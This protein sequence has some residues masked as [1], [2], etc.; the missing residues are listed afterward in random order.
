M[1]VRGQFIGHY[2]SALAFAYKHTGDQAFADR[3]D[4]MVQGLAEC[5]A[6]WGDGYLSAFP[7]SFWDRLESL[8]PVWAPYYVIHKLLAGLL[9]QHQLAQQPQA[10]DVALGM[11]AYYCGRCHKV[12]RE[13]GEEHWHK[14]LETE[15]GGMNEVLYHLYLETGDERWV[16]CAH[17][18]DKPAWF[19]PLAQG[20][21]TLPGRHANTHLA[22]VNGFAA[23][24]DA[25][26]DPK[27]AAAVANF[28]D[29]VTGSHSYS[30]GGS[31]WFEGWGQPKSLGDAIDN[32][33][34]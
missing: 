11:A 24:F 6:A 8:Q 20:Q 23:R 21:D 13:K 12:V 7:K 15:F 22:Q 1:E 3:G 26:G 9:A 2:L 16:E 33:S 30:T 17:L 4:A 29:I 31:N 18:F 14:V 28:F 32:V 34:T 27:A 19:D 10:L 25:T 5:Q